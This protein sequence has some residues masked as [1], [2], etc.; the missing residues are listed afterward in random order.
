M[1]VCI[2]VFIARELSILCFVSVCFLV[3]SFQ[4]VRMEGDK[5]DDGERKKNGTLNTSPQF[6]VLILL[7]RMFVCSW[8]ATCSMLAV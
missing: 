1:C 7:E 6:Y 2:G 4:L 8:C 5:G 3:T